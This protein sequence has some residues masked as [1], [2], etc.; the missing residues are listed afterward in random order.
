MPK[1]VFWNENQDMNNSTDVAIAVSN[2]MSIKYKTRSIL[3]QTNFENRRI[4][5]AFT[6]YD[7]LKASGT[8]ENRDIGIGALL[9]TVVSNKL[10]STVITNYAK[11]VLKDRLDIMYGVVSNEKEQ[12]LLMLQNLDYILKKADEVYDLVFV[13]LAKGTDNKDVENVLQSADII[14][15]VIDQDGIKLEDYLMNIENNKYLKDKQKIFVIGNYDEKSKYNVLN[16]RKKYRIK[17]PIYTVPYNYI[18]KDSVNDGFVIDFFY[19]N[20]NSEK[21]DYNGNFINETNNIVQKVI[22]LSK[23][24]DYE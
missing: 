11:P 1:I 20:L 22:E 8:F 6:P 13:D 12:Y 17:E 2:L 15:Y 19:R 24:K 14:V 9:K 7:E 21:T 18:F 16:I 3:M 10:T 23:I 4:E 5:S